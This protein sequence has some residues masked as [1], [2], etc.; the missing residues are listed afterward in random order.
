MAAALKALVCN[1]SSNSDSSDGN[2]SGE[3]EEEVLVAVR[4]PRGLALV[5]ALLGVLKAA[6]AYVPI[7]PSHP[8]ARQ[9]YMVRSLFIYRS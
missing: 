4:L 6:M 8:A 9:G 7:D 2:T 1:S 5:V 3:E